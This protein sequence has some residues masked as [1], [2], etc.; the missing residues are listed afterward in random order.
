MANLTD[1]L[2][3]SQIYFHTPSPIARTSF[4]HPICL[5]HFY[6]DKNYCVSRSSYD[7]FLIML[8][9]KGNGIAAVPDS[10]GFESSFQKNQIVLID[11][12]K[13]H[14][15]RATGD[16][17]FYWVHFD[18][19]NARAYYEYLTGLYGHIIS[20][21]PEQF[22][23]VTQNMKLLL[24]AFSSNCGLSEL[25]LGKYLTDILSFPAHSEHTFH[26][27]PQAS[28][29]SPSGPQTTGAAVSYMRQHLDEDITIEKLA[30]SLS[31]SPYYFIRLF[32]KEFGMP[33]HQYLLSLRLDSACFYL[34]TTQKTIKD[35]A[36]SCGFKSEN[37]FC[38]AFKKQIGL[39]PTEYRNE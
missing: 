19:I 35:I 7:S 8:I 13:P 30:S 14:I 39:T 36:F 25:L 16:L 9:A 31:I 17:E 33:P 38:I 37:N 18:G 4:L 10:K 6:C 29:S 15:Y 5:G 26:K 23:A 22:N 27:N 20:L 3:H 12:Y 32:K 28:S 1:P 24:Q 2:P 21:S 34:R 11:C